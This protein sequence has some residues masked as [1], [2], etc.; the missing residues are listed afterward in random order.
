MLELGDGHAD[1]PANTHAVAVGHDPEVGGVL[2]H[3]EG[4]LIAWVVGIRL[5]PREGVVN[6]EALKLGFQGD[7]QAALGVA[8][9]GNNGI[10]N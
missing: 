10:I 6:V 7:L 4:L 9:R 2:G 5:G 8:P 3:Q 1:L